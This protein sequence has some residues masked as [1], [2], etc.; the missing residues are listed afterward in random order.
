MNAAIRGVTRQALSLGLEVMGVRRGYDGLIDADYEPLGSR[1]VG[2]IMRQGGT[3]LL[4]SR[5][6][7]WRDP[8]IRE[9][10]VRRLRREGMD[11]LVVIGGNGS[12]RGALD[13]AALGFPVVGVPGSIDNDMGGTDMAIGT[14]TC[15]N[16]ILDAVDKIKDTAGSLHRPFIV[17]VMGR[18]CGYLALA[19]GLAGGAE[20][21]VIPET[22]ITLQD[23]K[24]AAEDAHE[25]GKPLFIAIVAEGARPRAVD[26]LK[27]F[28]ENPVGGFA[29]PRLTILGHVQRGGSPTAFDRILATRLGVAAVNALLAGETAGAVGLIGR[30][31]KVTPL[32][33]AVA[34][35]A[36]PDVRLAELAMVLAR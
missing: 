31:I 29:N 24:S 5:C 21:V 18:E 28:E 14:D 4:T 36:H 35:P 9:N 30:E 27:Y 2:S 10:T 34:N 20:L 25:R 23:I 7:R 17:E 16:T 8:D 12:Y 32:A 3:M 11:G 26:I 6:P 19:A 1:S 13:L 33:D 22:P 15:L